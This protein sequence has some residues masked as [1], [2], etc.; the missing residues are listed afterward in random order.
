M[1]QKAVSYHIL[2]RCGG[3]SEGVVDQE[4]YV[5]VDV[6]IHLIGLTCET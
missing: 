3:R 6:N 2:K 5:I 1:F 4:P